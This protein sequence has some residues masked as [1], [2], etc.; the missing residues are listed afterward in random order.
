M[1]E[2][3][4]PSTGALEGVRTIEFGQLLAGPYC[5][6][7]LG[8]FG[9]EVIKVE[10]PPKGDPMREWGRERVND[11][12]LWWPTLARNKKVVTLNLRV[13]EGQE[14]ALE[15]MAKADVA[16]ENFSPG[17]MEKWNIGPEQAMAKNPRLIYAR[18]SGYG[19]TGRYKDR[20]GFAA[21]GEAMGG[22]RYINGYP[23]QPPPRSGISLGDTLASK[24]AFE[25]ILLALYWRD[26]R[27]G[28]KGQVIDAAIV[29]ACFAMTESTITEYALTGVVRE[30]SGS[31]LSKIA[32]SNV[33]KS[34]DDKWVV[35]AAN[36]DSLWKRLVVVM[37]RPE[38]AEDPR[39]ATH[40]ERG[41]REHELYA[42]IDEWAAGYTAAELDEMLAE[43]NVVS[44]GVYTAADMFN[45]PHFRERGLIVD[46]EDPEIGT[47]PIPGI[48]P[49]LSETPGEIRWGGKWEVGADNEAVWCGLVGLTQS[50]LGKL[51]EAGIV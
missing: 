9:S 6:S 43:A 23:D 34:K 2:S 14:L 5:A 39:Y 1:S 20:V 44:A 25:G 7:L 3:E 12:T 47:M 35:I 21:A 26:A 22:L 32:P 46:L 24:Q 42:M 37:G 33:H 19:Q 49:K 40:R 50:E 36:H 13:P 29:D 51:Q 31:Y 27:G 4:T 30:P 16:L 10:A 28:N 17:T 8:D 48:T 41:D 15:L 45:D 38:L 11:H 18:V